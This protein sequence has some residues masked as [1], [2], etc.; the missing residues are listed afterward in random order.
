MKRFLQ[1]AASAAALLSAMP[2]FAGT[3]PDDAAEA[4]ALVRQVI[5]DWVKEEDPEAQISVY[6][7][8]LTKRALMHC[9][10]GYDAEIM[11]KK[12]SRVT[13]SVRLTCFGDE[14]G[15]KT[16]IPVKIAF[17]AP[18]VAVTAAVAKNQ[19]LDASNLEIR[20]VSKLQLKGAY[21]SDIESLAGSKARR[22]LPA[23]EVVK[24][25]QICMVCKDSLV[26]LEAGTDEVTVKV[27]GTAL[28]DGTLGAE[29]RVKNMISGKTVKGKVTGVD[30]VKISVR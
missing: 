12:A 16:S 11:K 24:M 10:D 27:K 22:D 18:A 4:E 8:D 7:P 21:F 6:V 13:N 5:E 28:E 17:L 3:D 25:N 29:I 14:N 1:A 23:G 20:M 9:P 15:W 30:H 19:T 26:D 2:T